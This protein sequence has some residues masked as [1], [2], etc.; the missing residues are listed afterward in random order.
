M[1]AYWPP[2]IST[3]TMK[4]RLRALAAFAL[5]ISLTG[6]LALAESTGEENKWS[7]RHI[8]VIEG[9][10]VLNSALASADPEAAGAIMVLVSPLAGTVGRS[11]AINA[12]GV[13]AFVSLGQYNRLE[14]SDEKYSRGEVF[15][16]NFVAWQAVV[17][18][19][20]VV[21]RLTGERSKA[22]K[23]AI[24][25]TDKGIKVAFGIAF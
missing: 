18:L 2:V 24:V 23:V 25:P 20:Y 7:P 15:V 22:A 11:N 6:Q 12:L 19:Y 8:A 1:P 14:L 17:G 9:L 3:L 4:I 5:F 10:I 13:G 21:E 16:R